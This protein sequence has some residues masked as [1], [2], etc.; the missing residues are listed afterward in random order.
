M[1]P[2][3]LFL[4]FDGV[5]HPLHCHESKHFTCLAGIEEVLRECPTVEV[6]LS[7]TWRLQYELDHLRRP[8]SED[9]R[10]RVVGI[11]PLASNLPDGPTRL[12]SFPRHKEAWH[13]MLQN[14]DASERW[15]AIDDRPYLF[16]PFFDSVVESNP[17][18]GADERVLT[19]LRMRLMQKSGGG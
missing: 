4:D 19:L 13:W 5:T 10:P 7:T 3:T 11:T 2:V 18:T 14:R 15:L 12:D 1:Q 8:F 9:I 17:R 16:R 6:V